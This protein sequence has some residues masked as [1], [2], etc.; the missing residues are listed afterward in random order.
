MAEQIGKKTHGPLSEMFTKPF[1]TTEPI[2]TAVAN[3]MLMDACS[4]YFNYCC[5]TCCGIPEIRFAGIPEDW[6][7]LVERCEKLKHYGMGKWYTV[8]KPILDEFV[9][10]AVHD[11]FNLDFWRT[12]YKRTGGSGGP[13]ISGWCVQL[14]PY[15]AE[16][17]VNPYLYNDCNKKMGCFEG[18]TM[19][20]VPSG[21]ST[22]KFEW[23]YLDT[24]YAMK[25]VVG[26]LGIHQDKETGSLS[27]AYG[28]AVL[29][30]KKKKPVKN[31]GY[32]STYKWGTLK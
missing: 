6:L 5:V 28:W 7:D 3:G 14:Y 30:D 31:P 25:L 10:A 23:V 4:E 15:L 20:N 21:L 9:N 17:K 11:K 32:L 1:S 29:E 12:M 8:L 27:P 18:L 22:V 26:P 24:T 16:D 19:E 2:H 13:Y